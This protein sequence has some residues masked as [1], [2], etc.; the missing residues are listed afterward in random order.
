LLKDFFGKFHFDAIFVNDGKN[1]NARVIFMS[2]YFNDFPFSTFTIFRVLCY[3]HNDFMTTNCTMCH[4]LWYKNIIGNSLII[5]NDKSKGTVIFKS[6]N[7]LRSEE[8]RVEKESR[9]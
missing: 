5:C 3:F 8:R 7:N 1:I 2:Q 6:T 4:A 9:A